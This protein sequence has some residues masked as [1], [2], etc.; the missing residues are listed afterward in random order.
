[1]RKNRY[2]R[3]EKQAGRREGEERRGE[4]G[5]AKWRWRAGITCHP[6]ARDK[7][8]PL[9]PQCTAPAHSRLRLPPH[10]TGTS[11]SFLVLL[12]PAARTI[13][14]CLNRIKTRESI[15]SIERMQDARQSDPQGSADAQYV[16]QTLPC[17]WNLTLSQ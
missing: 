15:L 14:C 4:G 7:K 5:G 9:V 12:F 13:Q 6:R 2:G 10:L 3:Q 1:M 17:H 16:M 11:F 8:E